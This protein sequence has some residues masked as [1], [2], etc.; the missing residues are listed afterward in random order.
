MPVIDSDRK[1]LSK[2]NKQMDRV[3]G[4]CLALCWGFYTA[5]ILADSDQAIQAASGLLARIQEAENNVDQQSANI[6]ALHQIQLDV[7]TPISEVDPQFLSVTIGA[8][9]I[10]ENWSGIPFTSRQ[11]I[12]LA[13]GLSPAMLRVGGSDEDFLIF[14]ASIEQ[15][16]PV[17]VSYHIIIIGHTASNT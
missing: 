4:I 14:N 16:K 5:I 10:R 8:G 13:R 6:N 9:R 1:R 3:Y 2:D 11:F 7:T 15:T 12:N 17:I